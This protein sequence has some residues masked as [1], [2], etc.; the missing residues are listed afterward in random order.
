MAVSTLQSVAE[1]QGYSIYTLR[2]DVI[3]LQVVPGMGA[4]ITSL[5]SLRSGREWL[6]RAYNPVRYFNNRA[7]DS[8]GDGPWVG[9]DE[10]IPSVGAC[11]WKERKVSD[12]GEVWFKPWELDEEAWSHGAILTRTQM[13]ASPFLFER[14]IRLEGEDLQFDYRL[15]NCG[16][17]AETYVWAIHPLFTIEKGDRIELPE[18]VTEVRVQGASGFEGF[19]QGSWVK[20]PEPGP[21]LR[22]DDLDRYGDRRASKLFSGALKQGRAAIANSR[23]KERVV[24]LWNVEENPAV[25]VWICTGALEN[26]Y[27]MAIEPTNVPAEFLAE[28]T[29]RADE[30]PLLQPGESVRWQLRIRVETF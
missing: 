23:L 26:F 12:H 19:E 4:K 20:W 11:E 3:E 18:D 21:G 27:Q 24:F 15:T 1:V 5:K 17:E 22:L 9:V 7:E 13:E 25:G 10:C 29:E 8:F 2:S 30:F 16:K 6:W 28:A 14:S